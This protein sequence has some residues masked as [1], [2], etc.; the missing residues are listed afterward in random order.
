MAA[1][2]IYSTQQIAKNCHVH[3]TT[4]ISW[5]EE[6]KLNAYTTPRG[7]RRIKRSDLIQFLKKYDLPLPDELLRSKIRILI[8]DDSADFLDEM[9][10]ALDDHGFDLDFALSGFEA[11]SKVY[12]K[13][14]D[15]ILL[16]FKMPGMD[17]FK[18]CNALKKDSSTCKIFI[19]AITALNSHDDIEK[20][21]QCGVNAYIPKPVDIDYL[22]RMIKK[23][24]GAI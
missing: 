9:K 10:A 17:G 2:K 1:R 21:K 8:V 6:G 11:G 24:L 23:T 19:F 13:K 14:P 5:I 20:I 7:H 22:L 3:Y 4:V 15:L 18:V 12:S 16:D